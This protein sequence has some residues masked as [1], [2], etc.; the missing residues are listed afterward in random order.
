M[1]RFDV[2]DAS[3]G[4]GEDRSLGSL[5]RDLSADA[6]VLIRQEV[7]LAKTEMRRNVGAIARDVGNM[8]MWGVVAAL[9]GLVMVAFLVAGLG[10]LLDNYWL[11]AL[12]VGLAF[13][14]LGALMALRSLRH[15]RTVQMKPQETVATLRDTQ[16]W[17]QGE[18]AEIKAA[19]SGRGDGAS[20]GDGDGRGGAVAAGPVVNRISARSVSDGRPRSG[21]GAAET[22]GTTTRAAAPAAA[23][24]SLPKRVWSE[25]KKD[26]I[27][28]QAAKVAYYFFLSLP[29]ALMAVFAL[30]GIF[31]GPEVAER[32]SGEL[33]AALPAEASGLVDEFVGQ[34][35]MEKKPGL[36]SIGL[37]LAL[38]S[39]SNVFNAMGDTLNVAYGVEEDR[40]WVKK[41]L[42]ALGTMI[43]VAV[44][45]LAGT[46][47][48]VAGPAISD[49]LGLGQV[50]RA[51][52]AVG[53]WPLA[54]LLIASAFWIIY[55][56]LPNKDQSDC[57]KTLFKA[58]A[59]AAGLWLLATFAFRL[60]VANFSSYSAT[61]GFIGAVI[62]LLLWMYVTSLVILLGGEVAA[63]MER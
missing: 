56:V 54:F 22:G 10:D 20:S 17:A 62:V 41:K 27:S 23:E 50:G 19:L 9:G 36:L 13:I 35:V 2:D 58:S 63:E 38:W 59:V 26:D 7:T 34:V 51:L 12:V 16:A 24:G 3:P 33:G 30:T 57:K 44:L 52:W 29:P 15:L 4:G 40:S 28:G 61:Y 6:S 25:F 11:A 60:Y 47:A 5:F 55:Y 39:A 14:A 49:A 21:A 43:A 18:A 32:I 42:V 31:G 1:R 48:L 53:Q 46:T 37:L 8:A 45:F